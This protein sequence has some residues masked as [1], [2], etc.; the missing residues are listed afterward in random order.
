MAT[1]LQSAAQVASNPNFRKTKAGIDLGKKLFTWSQADWLKLLKTN[2]TAIVSLLQAAGLNI[3]KGARITADAAQIIMSGGAFATG[4]SAGASMSSYMVPGAAALQAATDLM[5][6]TGLMRPDSP[7]SQLLTLG[8]DTVLVVASGGLNV[9]ADLKFVIDLVVAAGQGQQIADATAQSNLRDM[10]RARQ[11]PQTDA[12][13]LNFA[14]YHNGKIDMFVLMGKIAEQ[15]PDFFTNYFPQYASFFPMGEVQL[16]AESETSD[17]FGSHTSNA[18]MNVKTI[19]DHSHQ[20]ATLGVFRAFVLNPFS[21]FKNLDDQEKDQNKIR[22]TSLALLSMLP[23]YPLQYNSKV[24][25]LPLL[26]AN[27]L[28]PQDLGDPAL[29]NFLM[30]KKQIFKPT[31]TGITINGVDQ[32]LNPTQDFS[33]LNAKEQKLI[34]NDQTG[35][36]SG[37]LQDSEAKTFLNNWATPDFINS[38]YLGGAVKQVGRQVKPGESI[39]HNNLSPR[40]I[41]LLQGQIRQMSDYWGALSVLNMIKKDTYFSNL[42]GEFEGFSFMPDP[43]EFQNLHKTVLM[44]IHTRKLNRLAVQN[45]AMFLNTVTTNLRFLQTDGQAQVTYAH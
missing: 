28:T 25:V 13:S 20:A 27:D 35:N 40:Q 23:P 44:K 10:L 43:D 31:F 38:V 29:T 2:P 12:L 30:S 26:L 33:S 24:N 1:A 39:Q 7:M 8:T 17:F 19:M 15:S 41:Q 22:A 32:F 9:V 14:D 6:T 18:R 16:Y 11:K 34:D 5:I 45:I 21:K 37:L 42:K 3:P 36:I 4:I